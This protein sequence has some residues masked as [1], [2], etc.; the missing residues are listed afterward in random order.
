MAECIFF[1]DRRRSWFRRWLWRRP[2]GAPN[3]KERW[4]RGLE[5]PGRY[6]DSF[7]TDCCDDFGRASGYLLYSTRTCGGRAL[8]RISLVA[9]VFPLCHI[10]RNDADC[11]W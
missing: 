6:D 8:D 4:P 3:Q 1:V 2:G 5:R 10:D 9:A 11:F 7:D